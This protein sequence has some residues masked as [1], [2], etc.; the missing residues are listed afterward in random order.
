MTKFIS[1]ILSVL[2]LVMGGAIYIL[3]RSD[4]LIMFSWFDGIG[5]MPYIYT[6]RERL[7]DLLLPE[8]LI[9]SL[10]NALWIY[11][12]VTIIASIWIRNHYFLTVW[13][14]ICLFISVGQEIAQYYHILKGTYDKIDIFLLIFFY[15]LAAIQSAMVYKKSHYENEKKPQAIY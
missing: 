2:A 15:I 7:S 1:I 5:I 12:L 9:Y 6:L 14:I 11:S 8:F 4:H 3:F 10:P 13:L